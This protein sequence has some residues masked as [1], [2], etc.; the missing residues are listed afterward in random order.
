MKDTTQQF[1]EYVQQE[2]ETIINELLEATIG[3]RTVPLNREKE[4]EL[5]S[6]LLD[7]INSTESEQRSLQKER[8]FDQ[9]PESTLEQVPTLSEI[10]EVIFLYRSAL[11]D[12]AETK[13]DEESIQ[14]TLR[15]IIDY[16]DFVVSS[17]TFYY[18]DYQKQII[19]NMEEE[20]M[21]LL[22]PIVPIKEGIA[23]LP[24]IGELQ[25]DRIDYILNIVI[26][27]AVNMRLECLILDFSGIKTFDTYVAHHLFQINEILSLLGIEAIITGIRPDLAQISVQ[28]GIKVDKI[29]TFKNVQQA[30]ER[31]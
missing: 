28:L 23:V 15:R 18:T 19:R 7:R 9:C 13:V 6:Y 8:F 22:A 12:L 5:L 10:V 3:K 31:L 16:F 17:I 30:L 20:A 26:P 25:N 21:A 1:L 11:L 24:L 14:H 4:K 27:K 29:Q 2:K